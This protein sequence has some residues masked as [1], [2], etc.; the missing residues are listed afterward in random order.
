[1]YL[2]V[3][4]I[5]LVQLVAKPKPSNNLTSTPPPSPSPAILLYMNKNIVIA[6][7][8]VLVGGLVFG[9]LVYFKS[10][11]EEAVACPL[12]VMMCPD[13]SSV[14]RSGPNCEFDV[15]KASIESSN[16]PKNEQPLH[17]S[18]STEESSTTEQTSVEVQTPAPKTQ[19]EQDTSSF[20]TKVTKSVATNIDTVLQTI[21]ASIGVTT[22]TAAVNTQ[23]QNTQTSI[24]TPA[25]PPANLNEERFTISNNTILDQS[26]NIV[27]SIP[28]S[29]SNSSGSSGWETH[30]V[31]AIEVGTTT[32]VVDGVPVVGATG[33]YY[34]S[35]NSFGSVTNCEFSNKIFILDV[36]SATKTL[37]YEEN[38]STLSKDDQRACNSEIFLLATEDEKL[39]IK[40][41]TINTNMTC[42]STWSEP[43]KTWYLDVTNLTVP[44]KRYYISHE[45][46]SQAE[47]EEATCRQTLESN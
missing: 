9:G 46:Y 34:I 44:M 30:T 38:S 13:G 32:P 47:Q 19:T 22:P 24:Q 18:T 15:C 40:Y 26:G 11:K 6:L 16:E 37:L 41:H 36:V 25:T 14:P 31:N 8:V 4:G 10:K 45:R 12:D 23:T 3:R 35:E 42:E 33:K 20:F 2:L 39:I 43:D 21:A 17:A 29:V 27:A 7:M 5:T 1:M 28:S